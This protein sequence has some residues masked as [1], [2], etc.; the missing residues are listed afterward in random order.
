MSFSNSAIEKMIKDKNKELEECVNL[1]EEQLTD[2]N[3]FD[4]G[5]ALFHFGRMQ[6]LYAELQ[7]LMKNQK[8]L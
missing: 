4:R 1:V 3:D 6:A 7:S 2:E 5:M 8:I